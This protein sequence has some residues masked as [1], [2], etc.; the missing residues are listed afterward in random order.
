M[1]YI[2]RKALYWDNNGVET[3]LVSD[4][5]LPM[6]F[7]NAS[8]MMPSEIQAHR[9]EDEIVHNGVSINSNTWNL[10]G[11]WID[12]SE[13][14]QLVLLSKGESGQTNQIQLVWSTDQSAT[15]YANLAVASDNGQYGKLVTPILA[16]WVKINVK[17][18]R[19]DAAQVLTTKLIKM[20]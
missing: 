17:N 8:R 15:D 2:D 14:S 20:A 4:G 10:S 16:K 6:N 12:V 9:Y 1:G 18:N 5:E 11:T 13:F 19:T 7:K 3:P